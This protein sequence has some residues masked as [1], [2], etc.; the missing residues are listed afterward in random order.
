MV[1][2]S[3]HTDFKLELHLHHYFIPG[4]GTEVPSKPKGVTYFHAMLVLFLARTLTKSFFY[5]SCLLTCS[6]DCI[7]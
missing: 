2:W 3:L 1:G 7:L 4:W 5:K 6:A